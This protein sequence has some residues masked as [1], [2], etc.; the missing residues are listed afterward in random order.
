MIGG[1]L[2]ILRHIPFKVKIK[3]APH[4][5]NTAIRVQLTSKLSGNAAFFPD[6]RMHRSVMEGEKI[7]NLCLGL[8]PEY[9]DP[10]GRFADDFDEFTPLDTR[11]YTFSVN[12]N[13]ISQSHFNIINKAANAFPTHE[14]CANGPLRVYLEQW[15]PE[16]GGYVSIETL[17]PLIKEN[18]TDLMNIEKWVLMQAILELH[19]ERI[20]W[21]QIDS[22]TLATYSKFP[23]EN[24]V[25][26]HVVKFY[27]LDDEKMG[28]LWW[29]SGEGGEALF[30]QQFD[31]S[32][33]KNSVQHMP[34]HHCTNKPKAPLM[35]SLTCI[36]ENKLYKSG[37][38]LDHLKKGAL[39][40]SVVSRLIDYFTV[41]SKRE[42]LLSAMSVFS[43]LS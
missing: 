41:A 40:E 2:A 22:K 26:H 37:F 35:P 5:G 28:S 16:I 23:K 42:H 32:L 13:G 27:L 21:F 29:S 36:A 4:L 20:N 30:Q 11:I 8:N 39:P 10:E 18:G 31:L 3:R 24:N 33:W 9:D 1:Y 12:E 17:R 38:E 25:L 15:E 43:T 19:D 6:R 34:L 7:F 14:C